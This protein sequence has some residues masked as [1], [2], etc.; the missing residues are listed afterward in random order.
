MS[1]LYRSM[2]SQ[3]SDSEVIIEVPVFLIEELGW[4][5]NL[6]VLVELSRHQCKVV[7]SHG[8]C[9]GVAFILRGTESG[10]AEIEYL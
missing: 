2:S 10:K 5:F 6:E 7:W 3:T 8:P 4:G 9:K 1:E